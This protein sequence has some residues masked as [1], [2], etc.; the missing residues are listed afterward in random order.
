LETYR[1]IE[2]LH[3]KLVRDG[4]IG[5]DVDDMDMAWKRE[6]RRRKHL[7][8]TS[9]SNAPAATTQG[10]QAPI[11]C[12]TTQGKAAEDHQGPI[13]DMAMFQDQD[14]PLLPA[15]DSG[16][17]EKTQELFGSHVILSEEDQASYAQKL[18][19]NIRPPISMTT[20]SCLDNLKVQLRHGRYRIAYYKVYLPTVP[21]SPRSC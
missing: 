19:R 5:D 14:H 18:L 21:I 9:S 10:H 6:K 1:S 2:M 13:S 8:Q 20:M 15:T 17:E 16:E 11:S 12:A 3:D 4:S 7:T